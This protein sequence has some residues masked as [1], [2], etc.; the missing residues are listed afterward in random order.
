MLTKHDEKLLTILRPYF[1][2]EQREDEEAALRWFL[3]YQTA[4][5]LCDLRAKDVADL[6]MDGPLQAETSETFLDAFG[7]EDEDGEPLDERDEEAAQDEIEQV[8]FD[9]YGP[10]NPA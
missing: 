4:I 6:L 5:Q 7:W 10:R 9:F 1:G 8:A 2:P 3:A